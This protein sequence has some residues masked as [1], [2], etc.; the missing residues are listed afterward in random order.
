MAQG[1]HVTGTASTLGVALQQQMA[2]WQKLSLTEREARLIRLVASE[3][4][5]AVL[6]W[7]AHCVVCF[8][9]ADL[10]GSEAALAQAHAIATD[11]GDAEL[12]ALVE[13]LHRQRQAACTPTA[14][15]FQETLQ[16]AVQHLEAE[17]PAEALPLLE[18]AVAQALQEQQPLGVVMAQ[19]YLGQTLL[20]LQRPAEAVTVLRHTLELATQADQEE[21]VKAVQ[22]VLTVA[23][24]L[25]K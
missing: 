4:P 3:P 11:S 9:E 25:A 10:A 24:Q 7:L 21:L 22:Q 13:K 19:F 18:Q 12:V 17:Q 8:R 14:F 20:M 1:G 15:L 5:T 6:S 23:V 2:D 16:A